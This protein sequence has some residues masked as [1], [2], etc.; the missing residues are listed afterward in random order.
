MHGLEYWFGIYIRSFAQECIQ[1]D[2]G[3][4]IEITGSSMLQL[5]ILPA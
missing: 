1:E 2:L 5:W 3:E 4:W